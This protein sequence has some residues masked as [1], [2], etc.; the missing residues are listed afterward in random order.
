[1]ESQL[2][3]RGIAVRVLPLAQRTAS[4]GRAQ[5][6][7]PRTL[8]LSGRD[9]WGFVGR[10]A[11]LLRAE[12]AEL[13]VANTLKAAVLGSLA[14]RRARCPWV[15]HLHDRISADYL[16][17]A[18][19]PALRLLARTAHGVVANSH[20]TARLVRLLTGR[21]AVA[22]PGL[23]EESFVVAHQAPPTPVFGMLGRISSTKGQREFL[24]AA[25][26]VAA[27][28]PSAAFHIVGQALFN[29]HEYAKQLED[30]TSQLDLAGRVRF[31]YWSARPEADLDRF[32]ALV[33]AS[34]CRSR[35]AKSSPRPW[36]EECLSSRPQPHGAAEILT[37]AADPVPAPSPGEVLRTPLGQLVA[38]GDPHGLASAMRWVID[39]PGDAES[40]AQQASA[41]A[42]RR[43]GA[44]SAA[45]VCG[46]V[47]SQALAAA[48]PRRR[49][50][51]AG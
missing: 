39:N 32:S 40:A 22:Y 34:P 37:E 41:S 18:A 16:P 19:V 11:Q 24:Q 47:W 3:Q 13:V 14:A 49:R 33:H 29:D 45:A 9:S 26:T 4:R 51:D 31:A 15:W 36:P 23:P 48:S 27:A 46:E 42:R 43:F 10:L 50:G 12:Q 17:A 38:P 44:A 7:D 28:D 1:M 25:F 20:A 2:R 5:L 6:K 21:V 30:L 8:L 35:S